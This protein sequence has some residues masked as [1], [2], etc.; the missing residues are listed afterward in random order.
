VPAGLAVAVK[1]ADGANRARL[2]VAVGAL[3]SLGVRNEELDAL[4]EEPLLG[5][6]RPVGSVRLLPGV[7]A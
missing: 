2:P 5:G 7:F 6:G 4:A 1:I 3:R